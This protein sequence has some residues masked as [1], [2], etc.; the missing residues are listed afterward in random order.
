MVKPASW[1]LWQSYRSRAGKLVL[2][3]VL[4]LLSGPTAFAGP[5]PEH[6]V[7]KGSDWVI[8]VDAE[9]LAEAEALNP[10]FDAMTASSWGASLADMGIDARMDVSGIT[11]FGTVTRSPDAPGETTTM[12]RGGA[13]LRRAIQVH[14]QAHDGYTLV[15]RKSLQTDRRVTAWTIDTLSV[16]VALVPMTDAVSG[17]DSQPEF[18]AVLSDNSNRLQ[19]CIGLLLAE[20]TGGQPRT[21]PA[22]QAD[23]AE[24]EGNSVCPPAGSVLF[25]WAKGL[26]EAHPRLRS[27][28]LASA[29]SLRAHLGYREE[30]DQIVVFAG[31]EIQGA[32]QAS[33]DRIVS[34]LNSMLEFCTDRAFNLAGTRPELLELLP[35][36]EACE[37][38]REGSN[39]KL[40]ME[41]PIERAKE[42][43]LD[44]PKERN[45][46]A[47]KDR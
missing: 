15:L 40:A 27:E 37:I 30:D 26:D 28:L 11:M 20:R 10:L 12:L 2:V 22:Q 45:A 9:R 25:A 31:I 17:S 13:A 5:L 42:L 19:S 38:S 8:H 14:V 3:I 18:V 29:D 4:A 24:A 16:H 33:G 6:W 43:L 44:P 41:R 35:L 34:S 39:V 1:K 46:A 23:P 21:P 47:N 32:E 7:A 36:I